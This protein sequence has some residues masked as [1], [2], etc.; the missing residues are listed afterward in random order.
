M[1]RWYDIYDR[2]VRPTASNEPDLA[3]RF[4]VP[5]HIAIWNQP[6]TADQE[7]GRMSLDELKAAILTGV[8]S[9]KQNRYM[10]MPLE[11]RVDLIMPTESPLGTSSGAEQNPL[12]SSSD[13]PLL[14]R[15]LAEANEPRFVADDTSKFSIALEPRPA[16][17]SQPSTMVESAWDAARHPPPKNSRP[18]ML[19][20]MNTVYAPAWDEPPSASATYYEEATEPAFDYPELPDSVKT[21]DWYGRFNSVNP[22]PKLITNVFPWETG[23]GSR[24]AATRRFPKEK[25]SAEVSS[26]L[27]MEGDL[28]APADSNDMIRK[29]QVLNN[30]EYQQQKSSTSTDDH[31]TQHPHLSFA[32]SVASYTNAWDEVA[33][34]HSYAQRLTAAGIGVE[35]RTHSSSME[36]VAATPRATSTPPY[37]RPHPMVPPSSGSADG[38]DEDDDRDEVPR[39]RSGQR[40][41]RNSHRSYRDR[42]SQTE[43]LGVDA[44]VQTIPDSVAAA[45]LTR[46]SNWHS[47][48]SSARAKLVD[49]ST[50]V[51]R[52]ALGRQQSSRTWD[53]TTDLALR[54]QDSEEVLQRFMHTEMGNSRNA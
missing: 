44:V 10:S 20:P 3:K 46:R 45:T 11:G 5:E 18:E 7:V 37:D 1:A 19:V 6:A 23:I 50:D 33:S 36:T 53:P 47:Q 48:Q 39:A 30:S 15:R 2:F 27:N 25:P 26:G 29:T 22:D 41:S 13:D 12:S 38:D 4:T 35:R 42:E 8:A 17:Q 32:E 21:N 52:P 34:I 51:I 31:P 9:A 43:R 40:H 24:P 14:V 16:E 54:R 28:E 49:W